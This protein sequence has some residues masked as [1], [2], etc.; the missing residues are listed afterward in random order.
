MRPEQIKSNKFYKMAN[1]KYHE[2][3]EWDS[4]SSLAHI[5]KS[6]RK[7]KC[8]KENPE[9]LDVFDTKAIK[10][11]Q[12]TA[13][14]TY[15][16][17]PDNFDKDIFVMPA[18]SRRSKATTEAVGES[19]KA[20][21]KQDFFNEIIE[22]EKSL[23]SGY[24]ETARKLLQEPDNF[25]E[26]S[27]FYEDPETG[28]KLKTRP[29]FISPTGIIW[30]LKKHGD[31]RPFFSVA[32]DKNYDLQAAIALLIVSACTGVEHT[33]IGYIVVEKFPPYEW[34]VFLADDDYIMSGK[35]KLERALLI[36]AECK[37]TDTWLGIEDDYQLL[38][39]PQWRINQLLTGDM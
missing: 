10:F 12:G 6:P 37:K 31:I 15:F 18:E 24:Y 7:Y 29:D 13:V 17:E 34:Q 20:P 30:D 25:I 16:L 3:T 8:E 36:L 22:M 4:K 26:M 28:I 38:S 11:H 32:I 27:G 33:Q 19:G 5:L 35:E 1:E 21:I 2:L 14:H 39:P 9:T 23:N